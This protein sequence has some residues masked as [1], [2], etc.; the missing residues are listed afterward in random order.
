MMHK[1][2]TKYYENEVWKTNQFDNYS[3]R[4]VVM[5]CHVLKIDDYMRGKPIGADKDHIYLCESKYDV[6]K[7]VI[8]K[9]KNWQQCM[10]ESIRDEE[11][12][13]E[14][15][16]GPRSLKSIFV[17][18]ESN[19]NPSKR[20]RE[21]RDSFAEDSVAK[22]VLMTR[23]KLAFFVPNEVDRK[24]F[25]VRDE[26]GVLKWFPTPPLNIIKEK[27]LE[28]SKMY[29]DFIKK[30]KKSPKK[31]K[32]KIVVN[33]VVDEEEMVVDEVVSKKKEMGNERDLQNVLQGNLV[34]TELNNSLL[35]D[36]S[37]ISSLIH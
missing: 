19:Y 11:I 4:D 33:K 14:E 1:L 20:K 15:Y 37:T 34:L 25:S 35:K 17:N 10:P 7:M 18:E 26:D 13:L 12:E 36:I 29:M 24:P 3:I 5:K 9:I 8:K 6:D 30:Q 16:D 21:P 23:P 28:H 2:N 22:R 31:Q 32:A 27:P